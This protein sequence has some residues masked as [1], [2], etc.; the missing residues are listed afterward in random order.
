MMVTM[1]TIYLL[2]T[3]AIV[4]KSFVRPEKSARVMDYP[5]TSLVSINK[6]S[7]YNPQV[8]IL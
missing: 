5:P 1:K 8:S 3:N 4:I 6:I 7:V 2:Y